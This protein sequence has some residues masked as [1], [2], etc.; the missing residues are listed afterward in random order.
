MI[1]GSNHKIWLHLKKSYTNGTFISN[2]EYLEDNNNH[3]NAI[4]SYF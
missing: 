3:H 4:A 2:Y 1:L